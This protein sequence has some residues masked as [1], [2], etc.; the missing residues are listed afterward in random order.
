[1]LT[2]DFARL[3][4]AN[5]RLRAEQQSWTDGQLQTMRQQADQHRQDMMERTGVVLAF[6]VSF[7]LACGWWLGRPI[8]QLERAILR[9][10]RHELDDEISIR[11]PA[12]L[13]RLGERLEWLRT[14]LLELEAEKAR[15]L[16]HMSHEL[17]TPLTAIREGIELLVDEVAGE[18]APS[19]RQITR[20]LRQNTLALQRQI[21]SLL[22]FGKTRAAVGELH[23]APCSVDTVLEHVL[24]AHSLQLQ[25]RQLVLD[26]AIDVVSMVAD[27]NKLRTVFDN[28][29]SNAV[30]FSPIGGKIKIQLK[31]LGDCMQFD[32]V[33]QG[34]GVA[35]DERNRIFE[36][37]YQ[38]KH[39]PRTRVRGSGIGLSIAR[40]YV[41]LHGGNIA[42][43][44]PGSGTG[45]GFR[46][47]IPGSEGRLV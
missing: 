37:F 26:R 45:V 47:W 28:L 32:C 39:Q 46:V 12:D 31:K 43:L 44:D 27:E 14:R 20:I 22:D 3:A 29:I 1:V 16:R 17:K 21:E 19:Q 2:H 9:I 5:E 24:T 42:L 8:M 40:D 35:E 41:E 38:G 36:P 25:S 11:G 7:A 34:P 6:A 33:D 10:G 13:S 30:K 4:T 18:L 23:T 15:F